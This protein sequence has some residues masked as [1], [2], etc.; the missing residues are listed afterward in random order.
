MAN[1]KRPKI[2]YRAVPPNP[3]EPIELEEGS[4]CPTCSAIF[5]SKLKKIRKDKNGRL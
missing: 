1:V 4:K 5:S 3:V 2:P